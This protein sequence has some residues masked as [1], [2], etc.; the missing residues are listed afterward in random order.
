MRLPWN[1]ISI[2]WIFSLLFIRILCV[3]VCVLLI[4]D[5]SIRFKH[6]N[7]CSFAHN[8]FLILIIFIFFFPSSSSFPLCHRWRRRL[9]YRR[10]SNNPDCNL[11]CAFAYLSITYKFEYPAQFTCS[12]KHTCRAYFL[13]Q[14][15]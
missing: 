15:S 1:N 2:S 12:L 5:T 11:T 7:Q 8:V 6:F 13:S 14:F 4:S 9:R 10:K 3:S